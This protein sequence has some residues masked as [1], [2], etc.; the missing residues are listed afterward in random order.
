MW[1]I[2]KSPFG[3][4]E[5]PIEHMVALLSKEA[6]SGGTPLSEA[7]KKI[8]ASEVT[9][10]RPVPEELRVRATK[11]IEQILEKEK[12]QL[13]DAE[14]DPKSFGRTLEWAGDPDYPNI[15]ALTEE[16]VLSRRARAGQPHGHGQARLKNA[17]RLLVYGLLLV[18]LVILVVVI[19]GAVFHLK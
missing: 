13:G 14:G 10:A 9:R 3:R 1:P 4:H 6:E 2:R 5:D 19:V 18:F 12:A 15:V 7:D 17:A 16:V 11:L 8:L